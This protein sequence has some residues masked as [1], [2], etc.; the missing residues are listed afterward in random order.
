MHGVLG[1]LGGH[2]LDMEPSHSLAMVLA[3]SIARL[4]WD[5][6]SAVLSLGVARLHEQDGTFVLCVFL[7]K[8]AQFLTKL[9]N[10]VIAVRKLM[11]P[12]THF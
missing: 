8:H 1:A 3:V 11:R 10:V 2:V 5:L 12:H 4:G 9:P 7:S 6:R